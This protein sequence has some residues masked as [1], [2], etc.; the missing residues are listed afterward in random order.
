MIAFSACIGV[1][2]F[3]QSGRVVYLTGP[4]MAVIAYILIGTVMSSTMVCL[5][6]MTALFPVQGPLFE[7]PRRFLDDAVGYAVGW[8]SWFSWTVIIAAEV[9]AVA[10][11]WDF[12][13]EEE[14]LR[15]VRYPEE[16][17]RWPAGQSTSPAVWVGL[18]LCVI[19]A[20][21]VL[22]VRQ[23]GQLEFIFG[24]IKMT[25]ICILILFNVI[26]NAMQRIHHQ[27]N[28]RFWTYNDPY[29]FISQNYTLQAVPGQDEKV[30]LGTTGQLA[31]VWSAMTTI[32][33]SMI[34]FETVAITAAENQDLEKDETVKL[35]TRKIALRI[36]LLYSLTL[37][38]VGLNVPYTDPNL[39][40]LAVNSIRSGQNSIFI[41]AAVRNH[42]RVFP[43]V[44]N[45]FFIFSATTSGI[46]SLYNSSRLLHALASVDDA[47]PDVGFIKAI[48]RRLRMTWRGVPLNSVFVSW[49]FGML[50]FLG[51]Q[52][53]PTAIL[54]RI[55]TNSAVS[56]LI[57][58]TCVC[59]S[60]LVFYKT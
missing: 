14:Y 33:W 58:Y 45:G 26:I 36:T 24:S 43:S 11:L 13:F 51:A 40:D 42:V 44:M 15:E 41:L 30:I 50:A 35:G 22:P 8:L 23:Y 25:F 5:G 48:Q 2:F 3:L 1:G 31:G 38:I 46:N 17:L 7:F 29:G 49:L 18:F 4:G 57:V 54:G 39:R 28:S 37:L 6:E 27:G 12:G 19:G 52:P 60:Y 56:M 55:A 16:T 34:G 21:N 47:W 9:L 59:A 53:S 32:I 10:Q 20:V